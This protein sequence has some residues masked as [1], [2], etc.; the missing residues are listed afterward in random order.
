M[1]ERARERS[2]SREKDRAHERESARARSSVCL[3]ARERERKRE[4]QGA[5]ARERERERE[6]GLS[7]LQTFPVMR[8]PRM[9]GASSTN[10]CCPPLNTLGL[11]HIPLSPSPPPMVPTGRGRRIIRAQQPGYYG[12]N[13]QKSFTI[14]TLILIF[15]ILIFIITGRG[16][17]IIRTQQPRYCGINTQSPL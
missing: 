13:S 17:R 15:I 9:E 5:R 8:H 14:E 7:A 11:S 1:R 3:C 4:R 16:R 10:G 6:R 12:I 2:C